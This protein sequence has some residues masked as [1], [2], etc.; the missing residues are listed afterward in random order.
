MDFDP[1]CFFENPPRMKEDIKDYIKKLSENIVLKII[2]FCRNLF[3][4]ERLFSKH[5]KFAILAMCTDPVTIY[6]RHGLCIQNVKLKPI[7]KILCK[8]IDNAINNL[9]ENKY[10]NLDQLKDSVIWPF[11]RH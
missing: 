8:T 2:S 4:N 7:S 6:N 5:I 3:P 1:K 11:K 9:S 10:G